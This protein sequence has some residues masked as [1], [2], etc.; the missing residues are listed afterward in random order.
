MPELQI[1]LED[2]LYCS[3]CYEH[4]SE[5]YAPE[6]DMGIDRFNLM[7]FECATE[8][9][10]QDDSVEEFEKEQEGTGGIFR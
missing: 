5:L 10:K 8:A 1:D 3:R 6:F 2:N 4:V 7:C 9:E